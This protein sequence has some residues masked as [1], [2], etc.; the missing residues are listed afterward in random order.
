[1]MLVCRTV[2]LERLLL[3][4]ACRSVCRALEERILKKALLLARTAQL[5]HLLPQSRASFMDAGV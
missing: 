5:D 3:V 2:Q 1:M 4:L